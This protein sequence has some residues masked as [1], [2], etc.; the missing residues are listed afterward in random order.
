M[1]TL[2]ETATSTGEASIEA[3][4]AELERH[5]LGHEQLEPDNPG[6]GYHCT[7]MA[8]ATAQ[9]LTAT[10]RWLDQIADATEAEA[11]RQRWPRRRR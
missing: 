5:R 11:A 8:L 10:T 7:G 9:L 3:G 1:A 4:L 2:L 6:R